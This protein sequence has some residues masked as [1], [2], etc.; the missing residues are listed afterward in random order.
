MS[1]L[2]SVVDLLADHGGALF[3]GV[4]LVLLAG[5]GAV[6]GC[7]QA[8][9]RRQLGLLTVLAG[10]AFLLLAVVPLPRWQWDAVPTALP[11][12]SSA[13]PDPASP[14]A[15][16]DP[17]LRI[18][19]LLTTIDALVPAAE[20]PDPAS[21]HV[22]PAAPTLS[23][24]HLAASAY[25]GLGTLLLL[26]TVLGALR[27]RWLLHSTQ[28]GPQEL[29]RAAGLPPGARLCITDRPLR[30]FCAGV[31]R[32]CVVLPKDLLAPARAAQALAV[33]RHEAAH[34]RNRDP[35]AQL[36]LALLAVPLGAHPLFWWLCRD[37]R[38]Q[39]ELLADDAAA[40]AAGAGVYARSLI[41]FAESANPAFAAAGAVPVFHRQSEFF[42][43]IQMLL[44]RRGRLSPAPSR[45]RR[46]LHA[47]AACT[48]VAAAGSLFGVPLAAQDPTPA[49]A[50]LRE[51]NQRLRAELDALRAELQALRATLLQGDST[52]LVGSLTSDPR[53]H[54]E[55][56]R[57]L[58]GTSFGVADAPAGAPLDA[59]RT[60]QVRQGDSLSSIAKREL[61]DA[62]RA[63]EIQQANQG[64]DLSHLRVGQKLQL[65][66][67]ASPEAP[68]QDPS[69]ATADQP[70]AAGVPVLRDIPLM[71]NLFV[72]TDGDGL[73]DQSAPPSKPVPTERQPAGASA[74]ATADL[75]TRCLDLQGELEL[76]AATAGE[77]QQL[78]AAGRVS[79]V[80]AR[81]AT[82]HL[83]TLKRKQEIVQRLIRGEIEATQSELQWLALKQKEADQ[84]ERLRLDMQVQRATTRLV[85][86]RSVK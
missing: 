38:F 41:D 11:T 58:H 18:A 54:E 20:R 21:D 24:A 80:E 17:A 14:A 1:R 82:V 51:Q 40:A 3:V 73:P 39:S 86:L 64:V 81:K 28:P 74:E 56:L 66:G 85:V 33:L 47:L 71:R 5:C 78:A 53:L 61:G 25:L 69:K 68:P 2:A 15:P 42:R 22:A 34:L 6:I 84:T 16:V 45:A 63:A 19:A 76:A 65:P 32:P 8:A 44:Q 83:N 43:R 9:E 75:A 13:A 49:P 52:N 59:A 27:L 4:S 70:A 77:I 10:G 48:L 72:D 67:R 60:Y 36:L 62:A 35:Q 7:R 37:V 26:R 50:E 55:F 23:W 12:M 79:T 31:R 57:R 29:A 30:P 46:A